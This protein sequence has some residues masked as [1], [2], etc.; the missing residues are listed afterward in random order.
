MNDRPLAKITD[1]QFLDYCGDIDDNTVNSG[2][3]SPDA[4]IRAGEVAVAETRARWGRS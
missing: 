4:V 3:P 1:Q 2:S